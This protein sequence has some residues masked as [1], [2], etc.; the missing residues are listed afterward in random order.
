MNESAGYLEEYKTLREEML[1]LQRFALHILTFSVPI[2]AAIMGYALDSDSPYVSLAALIVLV[3]GIW[4]IKCIWND[5]LK[6]GKKVTGL[7][8]ETC[9]AELTGP[10]RHRFSI[11]LGLS[12][13]ELSAMLMLHL[14]I[15]ACLVVFFYKY[16]CHRGVILAIS[17]LI[18]YL[19]HTLGSLAFL[20]WA[21]DRQRHES[22][23]RNHG[24]KVR[25][26]GHPEDNRLDTG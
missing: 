6:V 10:V 9:L 25:G 26:H 2:A 20:R 7:N 3:P 18:A 21:F 11:K 13:Q 12:G 16:T 22:K 1:Q 5:M 14:S 17:L 24:E 4:F 8:W 15:L 23:W 19:V